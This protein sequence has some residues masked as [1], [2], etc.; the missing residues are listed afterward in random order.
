MA[1]QQVEANLIDTVLVS[2]LHGDHF[3]GLPFL[4]LD[5]QFRR[6]TR[7]RTVVGGISVWTRWPA[8]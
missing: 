7:D 1:Q 6:R 8:T 5:G 4:V 3:G 2:H